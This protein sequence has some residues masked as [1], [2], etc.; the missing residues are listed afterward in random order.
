MSA[1]DDLA[2]WRACWDLTPD[3]EA[4][5]APH[6]ASRLQP[7]LAAD[8]RRAMLKLALGE[9]EI[10]GNAVMAWWNGR[11]AAEVLA[12]EGAA[13]LLERLDGAASLVE[14]SQAGEDDRAT[15]ILCE[16]TLRLHRDAAGAPPLFELRRRFRALERQAQTA[17]PD[18]PT[19]AGV[20]A[21][22]QRLLDHAAPPVALH[23]DMHHANVLQGDRGWMAIDPKG[24]LGD[25]G[26]D[27][28]NML[29][30]PVP[31][32]SHAPGRLARQARVIADCAGRPLESVLS[33]AAAYAALSASWSLQDG[34]EKNA[35][36]AL[37]TARIA[38]AELA[39]TA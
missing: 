29:N 10:R 34:H 7:V 4:F 30:N 23:G 9:E 2:S 32:V 13:I 35:R 39:A 31:A 28:A 37:T 6:T 20:W 3:G 18:Q 25:A 19:Y 24:V 11:G 5:V 8:G 16:T 33:W 15:E 21:I 12:H 1:S 17:G 38:Q 26:Y 27:F 22:A 36:L 14:M